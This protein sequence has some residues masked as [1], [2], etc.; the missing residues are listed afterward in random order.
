M[1]SEMSCGVGSCGSGVGII[2]AAAGAAGQGAAACG[3]MHPPGAP[4]QAMPASGAT[5]YGQ[6]TNL[7][8]YVHKMQGGGSR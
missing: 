3:S 1:T 8:S 4:C 7:L 5:R 2:G 6:T